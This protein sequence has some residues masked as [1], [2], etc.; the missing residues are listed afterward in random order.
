MT[1]KTYEWN[2]TEKR[3]EEKKA[4]CLNHTHKAVLI[5]TWN[6]DDENYCFRDI[7]SRGKQKLDLVFLP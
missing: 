3:K 6:T 4:T 7:Y 2:E 1:E 5:I